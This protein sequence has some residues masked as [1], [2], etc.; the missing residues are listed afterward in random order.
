MAMLDVSC[1]YAGNSIT[2]RDT[3]VCLEDEDKHS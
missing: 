2:R 1:D 3:D